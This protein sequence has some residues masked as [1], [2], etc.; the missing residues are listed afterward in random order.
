MKKILISL[1]SLIGATLLSYAGNP[2]EVS[3][4]RAF[5]SGESLKYQL[6]YGWVKG[7][8][9]TLDVKEVVFDGKKVYHAKA[10]AYTTGWADRMY[11]VN[12]IYESYFDRKT[13]LPLKSI[14]N[15]S[16]GSYKYYNEVLFNH[17]DTSIISLRSGEKKLNQA[18]SI[19]CLLFII[20]GT[21]F[22][23]T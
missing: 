13:S 16:E 1:L 10:R 7:G 18:F 19:L 8:E 11:K 4:H 14:R 15:I 23:R 17:A 21:N 20:Q 9:A 12:D 22:S 2:A 6:F 5:K 3:G